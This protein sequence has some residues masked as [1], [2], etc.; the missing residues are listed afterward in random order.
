LVGCSFF[1]CCA[2]LGGIVS[3]EIRPSEANPA[4]TRF[5]DANLVLVEGSSSATPDLVVFLS[6]TGGKPLNNQALMQVVADQGYR[7]IGLSYNDS[8]AVVQ[9]CAADPSP[10]CSAA[11]RE[12][13]IYGRNST[14]LVQNSVDESIVARLVSLIT[15]LGAQHPEQHWTEY[16]F[17]AAP[18]WSHILVSGLSQGAGMAAYIAK[19]TRVARV[20]LF[21]SPWDYYGRS[22]APAPWLF[23]PSAT[24]PELWFAEYH[25]RE[26]TA[27]LL[28]AAYRALNIP[29][30]HVRVFDLDM[31]SQLQTGSGN[32]YHVSTTK[33][34]GY[35][36][37][38]RLLYGAPGPPGGGKTR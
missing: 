1:G 27:A 13:R 14:S 19:R 15:Y 16:L 17:D 35:A 18:R 20:V 24:P 10:A 6:G 29:P 11:V 5:N 31:P 12:K 4:V 23:E 21:S 7:V 36:D 26:P 9:L 30:A 22:R 2:A 3:Y 25:R 8:P 33:Q 28:R 34:L 38:W 37:E 32:P